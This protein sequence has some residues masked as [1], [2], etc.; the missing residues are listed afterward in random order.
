MI[1]QKAKHKA[2]G[3]LATVVLGALLGTAIPLSVFAQAGNL[4]EV[5]ASVGNYTTDPATYYNSVSGLSGNSLLFG[6][7]DLMISSH[8]KYTVYDDSGSNG[9]QAYTDKDPNNSNNIIAWY[10]HASIS[11]TW[12]SGATYNREHVWP[13]NLS[14]GLYGTAG[15]GAD[16]HHIRPTIS[17]INNYRSN[18]KYGYV[19]SSYSTTTYGS[20]N[21]V[22]KY[23]SSIFEPHDEVK[24]DAARIVMYMY[25]HYNSSQALGNGSSVE[26]Y[27]GTLPITYIINAASTSAAWDLLLDWNELDPVDVYETNRNNQVAI[28]QGNRNPFIDHPEYANLIWGTATAPTSLSL[29]PSSATV[30]IGST[31]TLTVTASPAG[32]STSVSWSTSNSNVATVSGGVVTGVAAGS[33]TITATSTMNGSVTATSSITVSTI[34]VTGVSLDSTASLGVGSTTTL[35]P[36]F[37]PS[38]ATNKT[39]SWSSSNTGVATINASSG[40]ITGVS[41]GESTITVTTADGNYTDTCLLTVSVMSAS[42]V[43]YTITAKNTVTKSGTSPVGSSATLVETYSTSKQMTSNNSQ[44]LTLAGWNGYRVTAITLSMKS[45]TSSGAGNFTYSTDG[46]SNYTT[47]IATAAFNTSSWNGA[48]STSYVPITKTGLSITA[49]SSNLVFKIAATVNSLYCE[50]YT[51]V[52]ESAVQS[53][54]LSNIAVTSQPTNKTYYSGESLDTTGLI[55]TATYSDTSTANVTSSCTFDPDPLTSGTT[56]VT[57]TYEEGGVTKTTSISGLTVTTNDLVSIAIKTPATQTTFTLG[58]TF[59][60]SGLVITATYS[61]SSTSDLSSGFDVG[62][63]DTSE[64]GMQTVNIWYGGKA[65]SYNAK[66]TNNG[67]SVGGGSGG[68]SSDLFISEYIEG[69]SYNKAIEIFNGTGASVDLSGYSLKLYSNGSTTA[70]QTLTLSSTLAN[71]DVYVVAHPQATSAILNVADATN[72]TVINFNGDDSVGLFKSTS[73]IDLFGN[74]TTGTDPG[75]SWTVTDYNGTSATTSDKTFVR[76]SSI[77][78]PSATSP[79]LANQWLTYS[80]DTTTY[81]GS[82]TFEGG[83]SSGDVTAEGQAIAWATY[84]LDCTTGTC[85]EMTGA[86]ASYWTD[87]SDEYG[88]MANLSKDTFVNNDNSNFIISDAAERYLLIV[89]KY[90]MDDFIVDGDGSAMQ[91]LT[92]TISTKTSSTSDEL[93]ILL[94]VIGLA[95]V[96]TGIYLYARRRNDEV[97]TE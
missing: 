18:S 15:A 93:L 32:S 55:I 40:L 96:S 64:L 76:H 52:Y 92:T 6:L 35:T 73:L 46:G 57:V 79:F 8:Q 90:G 74:I 11:K 43:T 60:Y 25:V 36:T 50:S 33:A 22:S 69:S 63:I 67:A 20:G 75:T 95:L 9:Y 21:L 80:V 68:S 23:T 17:Y 84:F 26:T 66:V 77:S 56:S 1:S 91:S 39:V 58:S 16:M 81:I 19:G 27:T 30:G 97:T 86:F 34:P 72:Q 48:W 61:D 53:K 49:T 2:F 83:G 28:Y 10:C 44:T 70:S 29:S 31:Q 82:H 42:E 5:N 85:E 3:F 7:H 88:Y 47:Q 12:D 14:N 41:A 62:E 65:T 59:S 38:N 45:N 78:A 37:T 89:N 54:T 24:G 71:N 51:F 4:S 94:V 13:Q 87:L